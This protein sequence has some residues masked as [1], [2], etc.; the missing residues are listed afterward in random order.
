MQH[1]GSRFA[2]QTPASFLQQQ[3]STGVVVV[4]VVVVVEVVEAIALFL[5]R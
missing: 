5:L 2:T 1:L 3:F 4:V